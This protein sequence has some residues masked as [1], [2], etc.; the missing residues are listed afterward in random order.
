[1]FKLM[2]LNQTHFPFSPIPSNYKLDFMN[3]IRNLSSQYPLLPS[4]LQVVKGCWKPL[5]KEQVVRVRWDRHFPQ[6][7]SHQQAV[8]APVSFHPN[9]V[10]GPEK[11]EDS[12]S[13]NS[14]SDY[15]WY[16]C[17]KN[18]IMSRYNYSIRTKT[19]M[20]LVAKLQP[21]PQCRLLWLTWLGCFSLSVF[22]P[23]HSYFH[24]Y[25]LQTFKQPTS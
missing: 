7:G 9:R 8:L 5:T 20:F 1:M 19:K 23:F 22:N 25:T 14:W 16:A 18:A 3:S 21:L 24:C 10:T 2:L 17:M 12:L 15:I 6:E 4:D 13:G 11:V